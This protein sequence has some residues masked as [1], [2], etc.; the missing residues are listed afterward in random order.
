MTLMAQVEETRMAAPKTRDQLVGYIW[1]YCQL[2][3]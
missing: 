1:F 3:H 2:L